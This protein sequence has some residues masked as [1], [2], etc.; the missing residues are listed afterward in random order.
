MLNLYTDVTNVNFDYLDGNCPHTVN[1]NCPGT[2][3]SV[4][5][6]TK[7]GYYFRTILK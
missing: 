4:Q 7:G 2:G 5:K 6:I 3:N 1:P